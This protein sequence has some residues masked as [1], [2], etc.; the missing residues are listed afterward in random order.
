MSKKIVFMGTPEFS[1]Q[2][3]KKIVESKY[4]VECVY[5]QKPKNLLE[6]KK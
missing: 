1:V 6:D 4:S 3:L 2:T 5:T